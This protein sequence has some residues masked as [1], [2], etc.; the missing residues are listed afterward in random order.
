MTVQRYSKLRIF[1]IIIGL[2][3]WYSLAWVA[4]SHAVTWYVTQ[5]GAGSNAS[6]T[7]AWEVAPSSIGQ[8]MS[9]SNFNS[10]LNWSGNGNID[11]GDTVYF[12]GT[13]TTPLVIPDG[14]GGLAG[15]YITLD[16]YEA[17]DSYDVVANTG[18][19]ASA[20]VIDPD[21]FYSAR[22][23][24]IYEAA[25]IIIQDFAIT[26]AKS[27]ILMSGGGSSGHMIFRRNYIHDIYDA[28][29]QTSFLTYSTVG[30]SL[31]DG[32]YFFDCDSKAKE[33]SSDGTVYSHDTASDIVISYN[34]MENTEQDI[35]DASNIITAA[36]GDRVLI[37]YNTFINPHG[38][39]CVS[40]KGKWNPE[41]RIVRFNKCSGAGQTG[42]VSMNT[43][44]STPGPD[45]NYIYAN[46]INDS[47]GCFNQGRHVQTNRIWSNVCI[48]TR[49]ADRGYNP[50]GIGAYIGA[51]EGYG[52]TTYVYN[53]TFGQNDMACG[54]GHSS[55]IRVYTA[56]DIDL[57]LKNNIFY[58]AAN[59]CTDRAIWVDN[60][61]LNQINELD[62]NTFYTDGT[63][64]I[65]YNSTDYTIAQ[66]NTTLSASNAVEDPS[67]TDTNGADNTDGTSDDD[68]TLSSAGTLGDDLS[69]T[70]ATVT[71]Q[72]KN[73]VMDY[74]LGLDPSGTDWTTT[75]PTVAVVSR[76]VHGWSR[77]AYVYTTDTSPPSVTV[78]NGDDYMSETSG[79]SARFQIDCTPVG[80]CTGVVVTYAFSGT[81]T[82]TDD[83]TARAPASETQVT[84]TGAA[85]SVYVDVEE[86]SSPEPT[87]TVIL[88]IID[89]VTYDLGTE[90]ISAPAY[91]YDNDGVVYD[92]GKN[93]MRGGIL[94]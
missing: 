69:G 53:N 44:L 81:A 45:K 15:N 17:S 89:G 73:Y 92:Y 76:D 25:Y 65:Y 20:A 67:F 40:L 51:D 4:S 60:A 85:T 64:Y 5:A 34:L 33:T 77:G 80:D 8:A 75:P 47:A 39:A 70:I 31:G 3:L 63:P 41:D 38:Q 57:Y 6:D 48:N 54:E 71:I 46:F 82:Y 23:I 7:G 62:K 94:R 61:N 1:L 29:L 42:F 52:G 58:Y 79:S 30:G 90:Y 12:S 14:E 59:T 55:A 91:I 26:G 32:N 16:G 9:M 50:G 87:E 68:Y 66:V 93:A 18:A 13:I 11:P 84:L 49:S 10:S 88:T 21:D 36:A 37:E 22:A 74:D 27:G 35:T 2:A 72:G 56:S 43:N 24:R 19:H 83:Y 28:C 78:S 86:D